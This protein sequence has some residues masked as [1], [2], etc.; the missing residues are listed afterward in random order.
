MENLDQWRTPIKNAKARISA[1]IQ[2]GKPQ[3]IAD[4]QNAAGELLDSL[5]KPPPIQQPETDYA[6]KLESLLSCESL[7]DVRNAL[8]PPPA[9]MPFDQL[10]KPQPVDWVLEDVLYRGGIGLAIGTPKCGKTTAMRT[11]AHRVATGG[12]TWAGKNLAGGQALYLDFEN[13]AG[14]SNWLWWKLADRKSA[15]ELLVLTSDALGRNPFEILDETLGQCDNP[16]IA[17]IDG[18]PAVLGDAAEGS[19]AGYE[20]IVL[21]MA[22]LRQ[23]AERYNIAV[24][25]QQ[26][27]PWK[28]DDKNG[29][30]RAMGSVAIT[31]QVDVLLAFDSVEGGGSHTVETSMIRHGRGIRAGTQLL[32]DTTTLAVDVAPTEPAPQQNMALDDESPEF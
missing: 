12:G 9:M 18:L 23:L 1:A 27:M 29:R 7:D 22:R 17:F 21:I 32:Q 19:N 11:I 6:G 16:T 13:P 15:G 4:A 5:A 20:R 14:L 26:H 25:C 28:I 8:A 3:R 10:P 31:G 24:L 2:S 30:A